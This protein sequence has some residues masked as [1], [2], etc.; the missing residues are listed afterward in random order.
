M[1]GKKLLE[2]TRDTLRRKNYSYR[3][4]QAYVSWIK[5]YILYHHLKHPEDLTEVDIESFPTYLAV[6]RNVAPSN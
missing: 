3:I 1:T 2:R 4:E 5:R 6:Q